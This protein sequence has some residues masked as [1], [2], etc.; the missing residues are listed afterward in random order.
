MY[1]LFLQRWN[2]SPITML[3]TFGF[4][5]AL[6]CSSIQQLCACLL[7]TNKNSTVMNSKLC[8]SNCGLS[9]PCLTEL[10]FYRL[11]DDA[12][13]S[14]SIQMV[15]CKLFL[16]LVRDDVFT[17]LNFNL[18]CIYICGSLLNMCE[19]CKLTLILFFFLRL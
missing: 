11:I 3:Y 7:Q 16:A 15:F 9:P 10:T 5:V 2:S 19:G 13:T 6:Q 8:Y 17:A 1:V 14:K 18:K 4:G 12:E